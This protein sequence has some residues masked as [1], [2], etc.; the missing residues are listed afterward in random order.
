MLTVE[1]T[2]ALAIEKDKAIEAEANKHGLT[3]R[4]DYDDEPL[5]DDTGS[6]EVRT[7]DDYTRL[8]GRIQQWEDGWNVILPDGLDHY[9]ELSEAFAS[10]AEASN[11]IR[12]TGYLDYE[13]SVGYLPAQRISWSQL[14]ADSLFT[15]RHAFATDN[16]EEV[17]SRR[18][19]FASPV[20][21]GVFSLD[22]VGGHAGKKFSTSGKRRKAR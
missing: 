17:K 22:G 5:C 13:T 3:V 9:E 19:F 15:M 12:F 8:V 11:K 10:L 21:I 16:Q 2:V 6:I 14:M 4:K 20:R 1:E 18:L 7:W